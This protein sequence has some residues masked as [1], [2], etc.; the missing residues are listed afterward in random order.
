M[1]KNQ[2]ILE[3]K[4]DDKIHQFICDPNS[5]LGEIHDALHQML[6]YIIQRMQEVVPKKEQLPEEV[7]KED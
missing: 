3:V 5:T 7:K 1:I 2:T 6:A 4:K